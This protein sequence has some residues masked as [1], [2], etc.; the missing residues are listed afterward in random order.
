MKISVGAITKTVELRPV[1]VE[2]L[3]KKGSEDISFNGR[4]GH[5][6]SPLVAT[7]VVTTPGKI[8]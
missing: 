4:Q 8:W 1:H 5:R 7:P 3:D 2:T 6:S